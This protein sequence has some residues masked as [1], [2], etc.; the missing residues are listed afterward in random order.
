NGSCAASRILGQRKVAVLGCVGKDEI[1]KKQVS[2][3]KQDGV[4]TSAVQTLTK[5]E[6]GQAYITV[7]EKGRNNIETHFGANAGLKRD[8]I[9]LPEVQN[10]FGKLPNEVSIDPTRILAWKITY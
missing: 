5:L 3:L 9:M 10:L 8:H 6:S 7:D 2:I 1:G 4:D